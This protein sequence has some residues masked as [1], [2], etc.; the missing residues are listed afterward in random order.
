MLLGSRALPAAAISRL[1]SD[2]GE[3]VPTFVMTGLPM[4]LLG[5][6][7]LFSFQSL[8]APRLSAES[9]RRK[10][11]LGATK[12]PLGKWASSASQSVGKLLYR[13]ASVI[14]SLPVIG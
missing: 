12:N 11:L 7:L 4:S 8:Q 13:A 14:K 6:S 2:R 1:L 9:Y 10:D 5:L 3:S